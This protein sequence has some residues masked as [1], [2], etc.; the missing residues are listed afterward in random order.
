MKD[1]VALSKK[2]FDNQAAE[3]DQRDT[4]YYSK[5]PKISCK[6]V[7]ERLQ[8]VPYVNLLDVGCGTGY[9]L[10]L[11]RK[12]KAAEYHGLDLSPEMLK[13]ARKKFGDDVV[14]VEGVADNLPYEDNTFDVVTCVQSFHHYPNPDKAMLE[15]YRVLKPRGLYILS[16]TGLGGIGGWIY[17]HIL[18]PIMKSGDYH[19]D[20]KDGIAKRMEKNGFRIQ[21]SYNIT[22]PIYTVIGRKE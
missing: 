8:D 11:L 14:L 10:E 20:N 15:A 12:Q 13:A 4:A 3:Y 1:Y 7:A 22:K 16:D 5:Y 19:T 6:D 17:N 9:L 2:H 21:K 18:F